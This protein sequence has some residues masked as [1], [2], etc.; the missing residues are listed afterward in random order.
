MHWVGIYRGRGLQEESGVGAL[1]SGTQ[2]RKREPECR[3]GLPR[4]GAA[5]EVRNG[6]TLTSR[7]RLQWYRC[8]TRA[9]SRAGHCVLRGRA[10]GESRLSSTPGSRLFGGL[11]EKG[12]P[13]PQEHTSPPGHQHPFIRFPLPTPAPRTNTDRDGGDVHGDSQRRKGLR[14]AAPAGEGLNDHKAAGGTVYVVQ[15]GCGPRGAG[16]G[17]VIGTAVAGGAAGCDPRLGIGRGHCGA[18]RS[19]AG[20]A[21]EGG[22]EIGR[23]GERPRVPGET[24]L[25]RRGG[26]K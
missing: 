14:T 18:E 3:A 20:L 22:V 23:C 26:P 1:G 9:A 15:R 17:A 19:S 5:R 7:R 11:R 16:H 21:G 8:C 13:P 6:G 4:V 2:R 25:A 10:L 12:A 24:P